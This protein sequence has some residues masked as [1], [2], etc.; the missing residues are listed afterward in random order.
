MGFAF[1]Q[2]IEILPLY[3]HEV[4][5]LNEQTIGLLWALNGGLIF[6][7]EMP[8]VEKIDKKY[9]HTN[10]IIFGLILFVLSFLILNT[11]YTLWIAIIG[12][13]LL[14]FG[15][16]F[17]FPFSNTYAMERSKK[18]NQGAYMAMYGMTFSVAF[19][20]GPNIGMYIVERFGYSVLWYAM[21]GVLFL[22]IIIILFLK[23]RI[24]LEKFKV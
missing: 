9:N 2:I 3:Y 17:S 4:I 1:V 11:K 6:L 14:T 10:I 8:I 13:L 20:L 18:G 22:S 7:V 5:Q 21:A 16:I 23:K 12:M 19:I 15:E 24:K